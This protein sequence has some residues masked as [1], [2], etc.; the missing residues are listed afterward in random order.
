VFILVKATTFYYFIQGTHCII[1]SKVQNH[2][3]RK[4]KFEEGCTLYLTIQLLIKL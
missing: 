1:V 3:C 2:T 4:V